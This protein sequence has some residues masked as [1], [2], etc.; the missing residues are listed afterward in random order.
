MKNPIKKLINDK[1]EYQEQ[2]ARI[3]TL[4]EDYRFV[5]EKIQVYMWSLAGGSGMDTLQTQYDLIDLFVSGAKDGK[6]VLEITGKDVATF[7]DELLRDNKLWANSIKN[8]L[9]YKINKKLNN[10][11]Q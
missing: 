8:R 6:H 5:Y 11:V 4:P 2:M 3:A 7:C 10:K 1:K 9:N